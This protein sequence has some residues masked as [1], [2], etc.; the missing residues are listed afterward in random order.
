MYTNTCN[1]NLG[2]P[3][4]IVVDCTKQK[5]WRKKSGILGNFRTGRLCSNKSQKAQ[6]Q[7]EEGALIVDL[8]FVLRAHSN[9][10]AVTRNASVLVA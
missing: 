8:L 2:K 5:S 9:R 3:D 6:R 7:E 10:V 4:R 1:E